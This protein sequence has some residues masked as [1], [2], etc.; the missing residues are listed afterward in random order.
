MVALT[1]TGRL[2][3]DIYL[4]AHHEV[5]GKP[6]LQPRAIGLGLAGGLLAELVLIR[7]IRVSGDGVAATSRVRP[8]DGLTPAVHL[9]VLG[10]RQRHCTGD[11]LA[12]LAQTATE[13]VARRLEHSGYLALAQSRRPWRAARWVPVDADCAFAP[14]IRVK[15]ALDP[16]RS[17]GQESTALAGL[18]VAC[19]LGP[20][21]L[22]YG[23]PGARR[24]LD[25]R[26]RQLSPDLRA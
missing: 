2:A 12:F 6:F 19:G 7:A 24:Q 14:L 15:A 22:A 5:S 18:A 13:D 11:W 26:I 9:Q 20:R 16:V 8:Q 1:G 21:L 3:D 10:E 4:L 25:E 23:P 17:G